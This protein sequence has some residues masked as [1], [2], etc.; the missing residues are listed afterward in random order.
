MKSLYLL[1]NKKEIAISMTMIEELKA[2]YQ[3]VFLTIRMLDQITSKLWS[4]H[5]FKALRANPRIPQ[6]LVNKCHNGKEEKAL[7]TTMEETRVNNH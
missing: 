6:G 2:E 7:I 1:R 4:N 3:A 5:R